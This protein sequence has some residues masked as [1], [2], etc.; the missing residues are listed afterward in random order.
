M[1]VDQIKISTLKYEASA[2]GQVYVGRLYHRD[3]CVDLGIIDD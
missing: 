3:S 2:L 1:A